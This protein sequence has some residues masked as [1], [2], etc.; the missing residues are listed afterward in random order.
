MSTH[1]FETQVP[2]TADP[3]TVA[4]RL[5]ASGL[6]DSYVVY[7][8]GGTWAYAGGVRAELTLDRTGAVLKQE[9][10]PDTVLPW[11]DKPLHQVSR[12]LDAVTIPGWRA[13][14][15]ATF[16]LS[17]AKDGD[18]DHV[19]ANRLLHLIVPKA[20]VR[21]I[22][23]A[24]HLRAADQRTMTDLIDT[25]TA[26]TVS[27]ENTPRPL[28]V[29]GLGVD[30]YQRS[31][32]LAVD[33]INAGDLHKVIL[34]RVVDVD[35]DV[36][37]V[38]TYQVGREGNNPARSFLLDLGG[39][40]ATGFSPEIVVKVSADGRVVSQPLAGTRALTPDLVVN[41]KLRNDLFGSAKEVYEHA[42]SVKVG[43]DELTDVCRPGSIEVP[44]FM[45]IK[46][47]G[48]CQHLASQVAGLLADGFATWDAFGAVFPAVTASGVPKVAAYEAIRNFEAESRGLYSGAV[49]TVDHTGE[50]DAALVLRSAY[51]Q[52]GR[53]WLRAGAG[54]VGQSTP[55]R[56]Y[57]E[58][59]EKLDSVARYLVPASGGRA[60]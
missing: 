42:I 27:E 25:V 28:D 41:E 3:V 58:T 55:E 39:I 50:M 22:A 10:A 59:C 33:S 38:A 30:Q 1:Y 15:W 2:L 21:I 31:V 14:G 37:L 47:R 17:Y 52:D 29:R 12:L 43:T 26:D 16:E 5:A 8:T 19:S 36:D 51:R 46:E 24:A 57:E 56:E 60:G 9:N 23:G 20:E 34:S 11:S 6:H 13:Y 45:A 32:Q 53:T 48:T 4:T 49:L 44:E 54:I 35:Y 18:L 40:E 7:E